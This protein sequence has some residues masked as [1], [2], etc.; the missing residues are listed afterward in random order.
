MV[1]LDT[2][3]ELMPHTA[4][5]FSEKQ[6]TETGEVLKM[7]HISNGVLIHNADVSRLLH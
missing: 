7:F 1:K 3:G 6:S 2:T 5:S 4:F